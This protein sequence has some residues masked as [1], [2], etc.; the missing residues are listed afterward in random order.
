MINEVR[1][2]EIVVLA[3]REHIAVR[4]RGWLGGD[5]AQQF[6]LACGCG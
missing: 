1:S 3:K 6:D 4:T 5:G 2:R